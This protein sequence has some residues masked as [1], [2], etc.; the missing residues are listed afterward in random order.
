MLRAYFY[1]ALHSPNLYI[2]FAG[3]IMLCLLSLNGWHNG[4]DVMTDMNLLIEIEGYRKVFVILA[5]CPFAAN[6]SEEW[7]KSVTLQYVTRKNVRRYA[8][9]NVVICYISAFIVV[10]VGLT[11]FAVSLSIFKDFY[12]PITIPMK[13]YG[14]FIYMGIPFL[15]TVSQNFVYAS[16]CAMWAVMGQMLSAFF[17]SK[18]IAI[19]SPFVFCYVIERLTFNFPD[20][21]NLY[22]I[23]VSYLNMNAVPALLYGNILFMAIAV[24]C[25]VIFISTVEK[26]VHNEFT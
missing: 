7:N 3:V 15:T 18:Y 26:R 25:A 23:S 13:P 1:K 11:L 17:P 6:F 19:C 2:G 4:I 14:E 9:A 16:S 22:Y 12:N 10:F 8:A 24:I 21:L 20:M 5:A